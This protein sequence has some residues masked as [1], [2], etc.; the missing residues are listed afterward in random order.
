MNKEDPSEVVPHQ[1]IQKQQNIDVAQIENVSSTILNHKINDGSEVHEKHIL[2]NGKEE[3]AMIRTPSVKL[4]RR[5]IYDEIWKIS[6]AGMAKKYDIPYTQLMKQIK[7]A[8]IPIPPS[9]YWTKLSFGKP[10]TKPELGEP[11]DE[12]ISLLALP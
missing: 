8:Q 2:E 7:E 9:G 6:V 12:A 10:V 4:T 3:A 5:Q 11:L 1:E